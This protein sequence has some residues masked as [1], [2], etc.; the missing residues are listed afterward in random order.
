M[1]EASKL[2][3]NSGTPQQVA[4]QLA[5]RIDYSS[6][7]ATK[8]KDQNYWLQLYAACLRVAMGGKP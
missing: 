6:P 1:S 2:T 7:L 5:E 4:F 3:I 8:D